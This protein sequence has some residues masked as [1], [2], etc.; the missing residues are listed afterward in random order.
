MYKSAAG[1]FQFKT[2][3]KLKYNMYTRNHKSCY[4]GMANSLVTSQLVF[5]TVKMT[6]EVVIRFV[7]L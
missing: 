7:R 5:H 3:K 2:R 1:V 6:N 4:S